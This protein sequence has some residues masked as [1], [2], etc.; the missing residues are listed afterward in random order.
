MLVPSVPQAIPRN[1]I[2]PQ[3]SKPPK[4]MDRNIYVSVSPEFLDLLP[5]RVEKVVV[6]VVPVEA[7]AV[8]VEQTELTAEAAQ[9]DEGQGEG[10]HVGKK[11]RSDD[12]K[13]KE[14]VTLKK[15]HQSTHP[16]KEDRLCSFVVRGEICPYSGECQ[17]SHDVFAFLSKKPVDLEGPCIA[18][19]KYGFCSNGLM[20]R[21]GGCH[22]DSATGVN[23]RRPAEQ[24]GVIER[25]H[26]NILKK[27]SQLLLR[28]KKFKELVAQPKALP[29]MPMPMPSSAA[30][31][32][33]GYNFTSY[34]DKTVKL[35]D[36]RNKVY[37]A[38]LTTVGNLPFRR[39]LKDFG[40]DITC[41][42]MAMAT[43][44]LNGQASEWALLRRHEKEDIFGVQVAGPNP[45]ILAELAQVLEHETQSDFVDLNC[46]C[47]ID[48]VCNRGS[49]SALMGNPKR[50]C[51]I[52][53]SMAQH[54]P[55]RS[56]TVKVRI[57]YDEKNPTTHKLI[58]QLQATA[59]GRL[60]AIM[61]SA[62]SPLPAIR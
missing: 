47:P 3:N 15:R 52:V 41:G 54:L 16:D 59:P 35:V 60:S 62:L 34:P 30:S 50:L 14:K 25:Q 44:I 39:V 8:C 19:E 23:M 57:G 10:D 42:E 45:N 31:S 55:S 9:L 26:I 33:E 38:P 2:T 56:I 5:S 40:A 17:Y 36:F 1:G 6:E 11:R 32:D 12:D 37:V 49:G 27:T 51:D 28:K 58:P 13:P 61:V 21:F 24:G 18:F 48:V 29:P 43:N 20:C 7:P 4:Q 46:G 53:R 22:I